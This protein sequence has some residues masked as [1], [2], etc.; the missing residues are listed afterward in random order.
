MAVVNIGP[1]K[2]VIPTDAK[3]HWSKFYA[4]ITGYLPG[5]TT[6][7]GTRWDPRLKFFRLGEGG[8]TS[9]QASASAPNWFGYPTITTEPRIPVEDDIRRFSAPLV[10]SLDADV[11]G[12]RTT[13]MPNLIRYP[14]TSKD[15]F[16]RKNLT[17]A[18]VTYVSG[19]RIDIL[20]S[21]LT[22][23]GNTG[24]PYY[25]EIGIF[26]DHPTITT[27]AL[28][29]DRALMIAYGVFPITLKTSADSWNITLSMYL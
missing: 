27:A 17:G 25:G 28:G 22:S 13:G 29:T 8:W 3:E 5:S 2:G 23:E 18:D 26:S 12:T 21:L 19:S 4:R 16:F 11:D 9:A 14:S 6:L 15:H 10:Q 20:C 24:S 7:I 1:V